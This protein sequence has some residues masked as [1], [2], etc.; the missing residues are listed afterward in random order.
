MWK[1]PLVRKY[2]HAIETSGNI[3]MR[4]WLDANIHAMIVFVLSQIETIEVGTDT[5][6]GYRHNTH[7]CPIGS[8]NA[9]ATPG[10]DFFPGMKEL[11]IT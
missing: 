11:T 10:I 1:R 4:G 5:T 8:F 2:I 7:I 9:L 3:F 6:F